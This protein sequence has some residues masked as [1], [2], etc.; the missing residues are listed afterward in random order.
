MAP[1]REMLN[2][3]G[4]TEQQ[5]RVLRVL[6]ETGSQDATTLAER[7]SL[8][9]PSLTRILN[10]MRTR[11]LVRLE[12]DTTDRRRHVIAITKEGR[13]LLGDNLPR[14]IEIAQEMQNRLGRAKLDQ[15]LDLLDEIGSR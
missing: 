14:A 8:L 4:L 6:D 11:G 1:I 10:A 2:E 9:M 13:T 7:S 15:L 3:S 12:Q 5:W